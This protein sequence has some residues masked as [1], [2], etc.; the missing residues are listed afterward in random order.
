MPYPALLLLLCFC[1][2]DLPAGIYTWQDA[3]GQTHFGDRP[4]DKAQASEVKVRIN[5]YHSP[6]IRSRDG[7]QILHDPH[8]VILY[9]TRW[10]GVC[11]RAKRFLIEN[12]IP[13]EEYDVEKSPQGRRDFKR[14]KGKGVPIILIGDRR[15]NGF[16]A[17][18]F[19]SV[20]Q[21]Q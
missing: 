13:F 14:L 19:A 3:Q 21:R 18:D 9:S 7:R 1:S 20:Y 6:E 16:S 15:L 11:K 10:C 12:R 8:Q 4:P 17:A 2:L 5:T